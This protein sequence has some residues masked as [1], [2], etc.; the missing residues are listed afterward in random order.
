M[1]M[2]VLFV[3]LEFVLPPDRG[4]R[5][6][7]LS[8]LRL[9]ASLD[10]VE[11][12]TFLA[13]R[14]EEI[15][16]ERLRAI[17][18]ELP[19]VRVVPPV[20]QP[21][22]MRKHPRYVP[23]LLAFR[24]LGVPYLIAKCDNLELRALLER[25]LRT[26]RYDV[27][28]FG[29]LG[30]TTYLRTVR[31]LAPRAR[32]VLEE[33]NVEWRIFD[34]LAD[35][36]EPPMYYVWKL[37]AAALRAYERKTL[38]RVDATIAISEA[39]ARELAELTGAGR[40]TVVPPVC[41]VRPPHDETTSAPRIAYLG[42]LVWQPNVYGLDWFCAKVWPLVRAKLPAATLTIAGSGLKRDDNGSLQVPSAWKVDGVTTIGFVDSLDA[43]FR[44]SLVLI[45][46]VVGGSGVR[47]KLLEGMAAGMPT[48]T[49]VD[50]AAGLDVADG[51]EVLV[52]D[53]PQGFADRVV[54]ALTDA[55]LRAS[56]REAGY[57][58][59]KANHS[60]AIAKERLERALAVR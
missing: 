22:H 5:V 4:L 29:Y 50:G 26:Q 60:R 58:F 54:R 20:F 17:E 48:V 12:I 53:D 37:E 52:S 44:E 2:N 14:D 28:Y 25:E 55:T 8:Q 9:L 46:P 23:R 49:T 43:F 42:Q 40:P 15:S 6:R 57:A 47:I 31:K 34:T 30:M 18:K 33:H 27:V 41:E 45:A 59:L 19:K 38:R 16:A 11:S 7:E 35:T 24:A 13:L 21:V 51:R 32:V 10:S 56:L 3:S 39:D 36:A 1:T